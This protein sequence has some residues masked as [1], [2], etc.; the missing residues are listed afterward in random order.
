MII[1]KNFVVVM[2]PRTGSV[3]TKQ[4]FKKALSDRDVIY[5]KHKQYAHHL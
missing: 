1:Y 2:P 5:I 4:L 3:T